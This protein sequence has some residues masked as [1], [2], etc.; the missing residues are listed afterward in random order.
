MTERR[1][2]VTLKNLGKL[3]SK[4]L[5]MRCSRQARLQPST[6]GQRGD[7][8]P[9]GQPRARRGPG[10]L[11]V[12]FATF[13]SR[14]HELGAVG[15]WRCLPGTSQLRESS[16]QAAGEQQ[17]RAA[18][19]CH[20]ARPAP[21]S[22]FPSS[23]SPPMAPP[24]WG[25]SSLSACR[26]LCL[27]A[28]GGKAAFP[29]PGPEPCDKCCPPRPSQGWRGESK[30][31]GEEMTFSPPYKARRCKVQPLLRSSPAALARIPCQAAWVPRHTS[32]LGWWG[33]GGNSWHCCWERVRSP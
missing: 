8:V 27:S 11:F 20:R 30:A 6:S 12:P 31:G 10:R 32:P 1:S 19:G 15:G 7:W 28:W 21:V 29:H 26:A 16:Q 14:S 18:W 23:S 17:V 33:L 13:G 22:A 25:S 5:A 9:P 3:E 2:L 24:S 4:G